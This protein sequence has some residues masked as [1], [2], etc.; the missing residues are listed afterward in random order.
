[1]SIESQ[2]NIYKQFNGI[3]KPGVC[4]GDDLGYLFKTLFTPDIIPDSIEDIAQKRFVKMWTNFARYGH[5]VFKKDPLL[6]I[7]WKPVKK[8]AVHYL[9]IGENLEMKCDPEITKMKFWD[10]IFKN[11]KPVSKL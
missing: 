9:D 5:P 7:R 1:M 3:N 11:K 2:L 6:N 4:H 10:E 8:D